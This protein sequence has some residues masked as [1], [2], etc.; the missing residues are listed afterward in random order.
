MALS[1]LLG[2]ISKILRDGGILTRGTA[3][4]SHDKAGKYETG[5]VKKI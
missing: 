4:L 5:V 2:G 1:N 3:F